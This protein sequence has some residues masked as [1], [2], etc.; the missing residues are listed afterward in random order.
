MS[1]CV[2]VCANPSAC[3]QI[4]FDHLPAMEI[5]GSSFGSPRLGPHLWNEEN[6]STLSC[7]KD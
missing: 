2:C 1:M 7:Y 6:N 3:V 4:P 5:W